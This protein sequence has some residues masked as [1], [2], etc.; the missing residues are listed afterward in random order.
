MHAVI[1]FIGI[2][3]FV[4]LVATIFKKMGFMQGDKELLEEHRKKKFKRD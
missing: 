4:W 1:V 2:I 3:V